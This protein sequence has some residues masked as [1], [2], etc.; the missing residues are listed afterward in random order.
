MLRCSARSHTDDAASGNVRRPVLRQPF[1]RRLTQLTAALVPWMSVLSVSGCKCE[2]NTKRPFTPF[3]VA[4]EV[5]P[6]EAL[7]TTDTSTATT[8]PTAF[9]R[10]TGQT[11]NPPAATVRVGDTELR[12]PDG[13]FIAQYVVLPSETNAVPS[14]VAWVVNG[15]DPESRLA[16]VDEPLFLLK[17]EENPKK[18]ASFPAYVPRSLDCTLDSALDVTGPRS[19]TWDVQ[20]SCP[21][22][23]LIARAP[24]RSIAVIDPTHAT[25]IRLQLR[26]AAPAADEHVEVV[27]TTQDVDNDGHDD[28]TVL[29]RMSA[30]SETSTQQKAGAAPAEARLT[31]LDRAAGMSRDNTEP[32]QSFISLGNLETLRAKG[33]NTSRQVQPRIQYARRL[34]A[35]LCKEAGTYRVTDVDG[36]AITCGDTRAAMDAWATADVT[37]SLTQNHYARALLAYEQASWFGSGVSDKTNAA[38]VKAIKAAISTRN[39][40][41]RGLDVRATA[42]TPGPHYSSLRYVEETLFIGTPTGVRRFRDGKLEDASDEVDAWPLVAFGPAG[43]RLTQLTFPCNE[44]VIYGA[45]QTNSGTFGVALTTD[46]L[47]SR[48]GV[49]DSRGTVP[50]VD[51]R[52]IAWTNEGLSAYV[53]PLAVGP[54]PK[55]RQP[56]SPQSN[57]G[58]FSI[59]TG[60]LGLVVQ[61]TKSTELWSPS[62]AVGRLTDCVIADSG[63][64]VAC[65]EDG[66]VVVLTATP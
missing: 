32:R 9:T 12:A 48:P 5:R 59:T 24:H 2:N 10:V 57:N 6:A 16:A 13:K 26:L 43:Q 61:D 30:A 14:V 37:A 11:V 65:I 34:F 66:R 58:N 31:W 15:S 29:F 36:T 54:T 33:P 27:V 53:G 25:P 7:A 41:S 52:P 42:P 64:Q 51:F 50:D 3:G 18:L 8:D 60:K 35:Y 20:A 38:L 47:S 19:V 45:S 39:V 40:H 23:T 21:P 49:C 1:S 56:G 44:A 62:P 63:K 22:G 17:P 4:T 28:A 55:F 46:I